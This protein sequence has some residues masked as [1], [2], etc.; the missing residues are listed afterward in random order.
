MT[1][2]AGRDL[3]WTSVISFYPYIKVMRS[4]YDPCLKDIETEAWGFV[5][6]HPTPFAVKL[7]L[8]SLCTAP[9]K[10]QLAICG[11]MSENMEQ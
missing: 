2:T 8:L 7:S 4:A 9:L 1:F 10:K 5:Q 3:L 11:N 6:G